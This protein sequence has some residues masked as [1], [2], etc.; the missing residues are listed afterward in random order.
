MKVYSAAKNGSATKEYFDLTGWSW[1]VGAVAIVVIGLML[2]WL[3]VITE[4]TY[5]GQPIVTWLYDITARRYDDIK[6]YDSTVESDFLGEPLVSALQSE[7][8]P[9][10]LDVGTGTGRL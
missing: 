8:A 2:Y 4:G 10:I 3:L 7:P 6:Q 5:L 9:L 1:L